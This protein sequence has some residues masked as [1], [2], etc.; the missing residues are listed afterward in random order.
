MQRLLTLMWIGVL[1]GATSASAD[2]SASVTAPQQEFDVWEWR[3]EGNSLLTNADIERTLYPLLGAHQTIASVENARRALEQ[4]YRD[5]GYPT[6]LVDIPEQEVNSGVVA[7]RV[8]EARIERLRITGARYYS[9]RDMSVTLRALAQGSVLYTTAVQE[10]LN[11][12]NARSANRAVTPV[13]RPGKTP[14]T[15]EVELKVKDELPLHASLELNDRSGS[16]TARWRSIAMLRYDNLWQRE[17]SIALQY[18]TAP[19][20]PEQVRVYSGTYVARFN[21]T[22]NVLAAYGVHSSSSSAA[23]GDISVIGNGDI[24]GLRAIVPFAALP[25]YTHS[26]SFGVD[27]KDFKE[28]LRVLGQD[29]PLSTP[30]NYATFTAQYTANLPAEKSSTRFN[31]GVNFG[32]RGVSDDT[33][34]CQRL[35][36]DIVGNKIIDSQPYSEFGCKRPGARANYFYLRAGAEHNGEI[37]SGYTWRAALDMQISDSPLISNEQ[38]SVGGADSVRGYYESQALG[39]NGARATLELSTPSFGTRWPDQIQELRALVFSDAALLKIREAGAGEE[40][41]IELSSAGIGVRF[42]AWGGLRG[43]LD[44]AQVFNAN[45]HVDSG[46][47]HVHARVEYA[48]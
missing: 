36:L 45:G 32:L 8:T 10:Q 25:N 19:E 3:V 24:Y 18:Q 20:E 31:L 34:A 43:A 16:G 26:A 11:G 6:V 9:S 35:A 22:D 27:Y 47:T 48:F 29:N 2:E 4:R 15:V 40:D 5:L 17:H 7:L 37:F 13:L 1:I 42:T 23:I 38:Y 14:G 33:I 44:W 39:D 46:D 21:D 41:H 28:N 12:V 30:I